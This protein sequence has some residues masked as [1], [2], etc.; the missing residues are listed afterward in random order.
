MVD[1][2]HFP[3]GLSRRDRRRRDSL[4]PGRSAPLLFSRSQIQHGQI[5]GECYWRGSFRVHF[6]LGGSCSFSV[7]RD[8][9]TDSP[10]SYPATGFGSRIISPG[11]AGLV[12]ARE[13]W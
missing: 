10:A 4:I 7:D 11:S 2:G 1:T 13:E 6:L 3:N 9:S 12:S 5:H 8:T